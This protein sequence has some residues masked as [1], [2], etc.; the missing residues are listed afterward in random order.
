MKR[1]IALFLV[2][3]VAGT[4]VKAQEIPE[5]KSERPNMMHHGKH[6]HH[7]MGMDM[8]A[9][10][11][12]E[13][14]KAQ[15]KAQRENFQKQMEELK[16]NDNITVKEYR[17]RMESIRKEQHSKMQ[18]IL[19][20]EQKTQMQKMK[21]EADTKRE[22]FGK[23]RGEKMKAAL[24]LSADQSAKLDA[25]RKEIGEKMRSIRENKSLSDDQKKAEMKKIM[26][27]NKE[28]MKSILTEE[29]M[30]KMKEMHRGHRGDGDRK[31][32]EA[33]KQTI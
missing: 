19:T 9:L 27:G 13:D 7:D 26:E 5:R 12:T 17:T 14:Q 25:N 10:N 30:K 31:K 21:A 32:V 24:G 18:S 3:A 1:I 33:E 2:A 23:E 4:S 15:F 6:G 11:L 28:K 16:K 22:Q 29:Q 20:A 8:K